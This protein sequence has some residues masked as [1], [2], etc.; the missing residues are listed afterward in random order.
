MQAA[1]RVPYTR[2][3]RPE[4]DIDG[5]GC[6][7]PKDTLPPREASAGWKLEH[8]SPLHDVILVVTPIYE[9]HESDPLGLD[10]KVKLL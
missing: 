9:N 4:Q 3:T 8:K 6:V 2:V 7:R 1:V 10:S 5:S